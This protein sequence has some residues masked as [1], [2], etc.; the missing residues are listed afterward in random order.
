MSICKNCGKEIES[1][2]VVCLNC[3]A[4]VDFSNQSHS[5]IAWDRDVEG[6]NS[7]STAANQI[8]DVQNISTG[9]NQIEK[10]AL[11]EARK[12]LVQSLHSILIKK[13]EEQQDSKPIPDYKQVTRINLGNDT[14]KAYEK[15][16]SQKI[17]DSQENLTEKTVNHNRNLSNDKN[18]EIVE[19]YNSPGKNKS[20]KIPEVFNSVSFWIK[21]ILM[22]TMFVLSYLSDKDKEYHSYENSKKRWDVIDKA[23]QENGY[24]SIPDGDVKDLLEQNQKGM[25][26]YDEMFK[27]KYE[28]ENKLNS[29]ENEN[30][31]NDIEDENQ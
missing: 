7:M 26:I 1:G 11:T 22:I 19:K 15:Q 3:G 21:L 13:I 27:E 30:Y 28:E 10:K 23:I 31:E 6:N 12:A 17:Q 8:E 9:I 20:Y 14:K 18:Q 29:R 4:L 24:P 5:S 2:H 16:E 25:E